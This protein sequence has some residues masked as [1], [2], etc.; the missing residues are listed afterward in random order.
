M[1]LTIDR[2]PPDAT[3]ATTSLYR[4]L[5]DWGEGASNPFGPEGQGVAAQ[6]GD[7]TWIHTF[8]DTQTW[9][10]A[11]GD[12]AGTVSASTSFA[13]GAETLTFGPTEPLVADVQAWVNAPGEN[14]GWIVI[15]DEVATMNAR[16]LLS[17]ENGDPGVPALTVVFTP[18]PDLPEPRTVPTLGIAGYVLLFLTLFITAVAFRKFL[19]TSSGNADQN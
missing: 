18:A 2:V 11:G 3:G 14:F 17:R 4:L 5:S 12:Y 19:T 13:N 1:N 9:A 8:F 10:T 15:G 16:R 7:A 6:P